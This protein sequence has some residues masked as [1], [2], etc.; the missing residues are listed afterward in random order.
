MYLHICSTVYKIFSCKIQM[1]DTY[2]IFLY[3]MPQKVIV[4]NIHNFCFCSVRQFLIIY[5]NKIVFNKVK[6]IH[7]MYQ[8][9]LT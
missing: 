7:I 3:F 5:F 2:N 9:K 8:K 4:C 6:V 1:H